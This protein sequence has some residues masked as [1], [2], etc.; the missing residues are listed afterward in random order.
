MGHTP[1][2]E[3]NAVVRRMEDAHWPG[4]GHMSTKGLGWGQRL[5]HR[6]GKWV[7]GVSPKENHGVV[8]KKKGRWG[9]SMMKKK[10]IQVCLGS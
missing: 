10:K 2:P 1:I 9:K 5:S 3:P 8:T 4:L 6:E 7:S